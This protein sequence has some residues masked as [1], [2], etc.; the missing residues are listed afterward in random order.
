M[1][2]A[3]IE[4][5]IIP[6]DR[7]VEMWLEGDLSFSIEGQ[8]FSIKARVARVNEGDTGLRFRI[9]SEADK[10]AI[11]KLLALGQPQN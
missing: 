8:Q 9:D 6:F 5:E 10:L 11:Q 1:F 4:S 2:M 7:P 3:G